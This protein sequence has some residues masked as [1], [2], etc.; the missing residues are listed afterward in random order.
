MGHVLSRQR[1]ARVWLAEVRD[2][3]VEN[4]RAQLDDGEA[5]CD[6]LILATGSHHHYFG[7]EEWTRAGAGAQ[8]HTG[9]G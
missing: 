8:D 9:H 4:R 7:Q 6:T 5:A 1:N 2:I 3:D